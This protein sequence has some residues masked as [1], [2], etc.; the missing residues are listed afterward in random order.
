GRFFQSP[1][2]FQRRS[3]ARSSPPTLSTREPPPPAS[4]DRARRERH[5]FSSSFWDNRAGMF[6]STTPAAFD[7][8]R[9]VRAARPYTPLRLSSFGPPA[10]PLLRPRR[11]KMATHPLQS[12]P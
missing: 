5:E 2:L 11:L 4:G 3:K 12:F 8:L 6:Q 1:A 10:P 9:N 7:F